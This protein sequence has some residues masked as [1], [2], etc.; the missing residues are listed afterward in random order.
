MENMMKKILTLLLILPSLMSYADGVNL[1]PVSSMSSVVVQKA[2]AS[3]VT[4][5]TNQVQYQLILGG[6]AIMKSNNSVAALSANSSSNNL[7]ADDHGP[8][9]ISIGTGGQ[10]VNNSLSANGVNFKQIAYNPD[11]GKVAIIVGDIVVK[12]R[13]SYSAEAI[14]A[15]YNINLV[16]NFKDI[17][18]AWYQVKA[19]QDIFA[20]AQNI[21]GHAGVESAE[22]EI[23]EDYREPR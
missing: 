16:E 19:G 10:S 8:Y 2:L 23:I 17:S 21:S 11:S 3:G 18:Y 6:R 15:T 9:L 14:A 12:I 13:P 4:F 7:W 5:T 1:N 22:I 20:I